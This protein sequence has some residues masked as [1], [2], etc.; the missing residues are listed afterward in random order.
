M[1]IYVSVCFKDMQIAK[2]HI[3]KKTSIEVKSSEIGF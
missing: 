2:Q 3:Q 1:D